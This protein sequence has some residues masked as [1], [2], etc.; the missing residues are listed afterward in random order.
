MNKIFITA[1]A[2][3]AASPA[4]ASD[5]LA[6]SLGVE[7]GR[8]TLAELV[9][10]KAASTFESNEGSVYLGNPRDFSTQS[11][12]SPTALMQFRAAI[13]ESNSTGLAN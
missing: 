4:L 6:L 10:I 12:H 5:Q 9:E 13:E 8:Y 3:A 2:L 11:I 1:I 7:P